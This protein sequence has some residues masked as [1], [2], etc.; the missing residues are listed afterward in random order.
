MP[1]DR[2][3]DESTARVAEEA[4]PGWKPVHETSLS[5]PSSSRNAHA[6]DHAPGAPDAD[7]IMPTIEELRAKYL[8]AEAAMDA[9]SATDPDAPTDNNDVSL[10]ELESGP[11]KKTAAV[12]KSKKR[13]LW[14]QG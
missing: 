5:T 10:V 6:A 13:V 2:T 4:F 9:P 7:V 8:G 1:R 12:S 3:S 14:S 11:L